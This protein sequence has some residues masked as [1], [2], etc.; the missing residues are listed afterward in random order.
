MLRLVFNRSVSSVQKVVTRC[1]PGWKP[2]SIIS[3]RATVV[4]GAIQ[5]VPQRSLT[6]GDRFQ[7]EV[8]DVKVRGNS[9]SETHRYEVRVPPG[10]KVLRTSSAYGHEPHRRM[11]VTFDQKLRRAHGRRDC[12]R[13]EAVLDAEDK[14]KDKDKGGTGKNVPVSVVTAGS[15]LYIKP[16][17]LLGSCQELQLTLGTCHTSAAG[18]PAREWSKRFRT[19]CARL[20]NLGRSVEGRR[21]RAHVFGNGARKLLFFGG[22]HG[23]EYNTTRLMKNWSYLLEARARSLPKGVTIAVVHSINPDGLVAKRRYNARWVDLNR[24]FLTKNWSQATTWQHR[25]LSNAGGAR[26]FSEPETRAL[27]DL[28]NRLKPMLSL[29]YHSAGRM[30]QSNQL[31]AADRWAKLYARSSGYPLNKQLPYAVTGSFADW[32]RERG[33]PAL[34]I[35]LSFKHIAEFK[36]NQTAMWQIV[37]QV[38]GGGRR[39]TKQKRR[40]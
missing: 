16:T 17:R 21:I 12:V 26:A 2:C 19:R 28:I 7:V 10:P 40:P 20:W 4:D 23:D 8:F 25:K 6:S 1:P 9:G 15:K 13:L 27:R 24:N 29:S 11:I 30:V 34:T 18:W 3:L 35:E 38:A 33:L 39:T 14:D 36:R 22:I 37:K 31:P 5:A 32:C